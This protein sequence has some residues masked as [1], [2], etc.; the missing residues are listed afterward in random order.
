MRLF[1]PPLSLR[2]ISPTRGE[3]V[4]ARSVFLASFVV[5]FECYMDV[6]SRGNYSPPLWGRCPTGQR[7]VS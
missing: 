4:E 2:D 3:S 7:G 5:C 6:V 1:Y